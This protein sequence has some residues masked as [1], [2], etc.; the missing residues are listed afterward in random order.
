MTAQTK[1]RLSPEQETMLIT[2]YARA[3]ADNPLFYDPISRQVLDQIDYDFSS[4]HVPY[5]TVVL[6]CQ[7]AKKLD[8][9]VREF[10]EE[11]P[12]SVVLQLGAGLDSRFQRVDNGQVCWYD[13]DM[14]P[15]IELRRQFFEENDRY[16]MISSSVTNLAWMDNVNAGERPVLVV[17]EGL[18]MYLGESD[19]RKL[20]LR[21]Q[22]RFPACRLAADVF[23]RMTARS[24]T[25]RTTWYTHVMQRAALF[26]CS[27]LRCLHHYGS[28]RS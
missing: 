23:S 6:V 15:V 22:E 10:L 17:A 26:L 8:A 1:V 28:D 13:L 20:L 21:L 3:Q 2:L 24:A 4:L 16:R 11:Q 5:K 9:I 12:D 14:P 19:V 25:N 7:R 18:L 27:E